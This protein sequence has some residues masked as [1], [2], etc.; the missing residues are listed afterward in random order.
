ME[1]SLN[2][3]SRVWVSPGSFWLQDPRCSVS[4]LPWLSVVLSQG[5][6][7]S[8]F[9]GKSVPSK[10]SKWQSRKLP[11]GKATQEEDLSESAPR[12]QPR[13]GLLTETLVFQSLAIPVSPSVALT[14]GTS[15]QLHSWE[16]DFTE[17]VQHKFPSS[18]QVS[19]ASIKYLL[20]QR[21]TSHWSFLC[22]S[23]PKV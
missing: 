15:I 3:T 16:R 9:R 11:A 17:Q 6:T 18:K 19:S 7:F 21:S 20:R 5:A 10:S 1:S 4:D 12:N 23:S 2:A 22:S 8:F 14:Q 13:L